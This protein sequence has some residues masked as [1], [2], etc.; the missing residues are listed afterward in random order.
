MAK[1]TAAVAIGTE[2]C[3][4]LSRWWSLEKATAKEITAAIRYG[5]AVQTSVIVR[6]PNPKPSTMEG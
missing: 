2:M 6:E 4:P 5:G 1:P 3:H